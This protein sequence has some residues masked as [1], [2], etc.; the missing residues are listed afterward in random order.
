MGEVLIPPRLISIPSKESKIKNKQQKIRDTQSNHI[1]FINNV[2]ES[3]VVITSNQKLRKVIFAHCEKSKLQV[4]DSAVITTKTVE[5]FDCHNCVFTFDEVDVRI[6]HIYECN[7][8]T[9]QFSDS[10]TLIENFQIYWHGPESKGNSLQRTIIKP[11]A[12]PN[13][14]TAIPVELIEAY[15]VPDVENDDDVLLTFLEEGK[16]LRSTLNPPNDPQAKRTLVDLH[17]EIK[18]RL[19]DNEEFNKVVTN[20]MLTQ[21][22]D[23]EREEIEEDDEIVKQKAAEVAD[24]IKKGKHVVFYTG[25]G[26]ST[27]ANL[28]D[29][30]GPQGVWTLRATGNA[31]TKPTLELGEAQPTFTHYAIAELI[32]RNLVHFLT[33]TNLDGL[34]RRSGVPGSKISELHGNCYKEVCSV[35]QKEYLRSFNTLNTRTDR[36]THFTYRNCTCGGMLMDTIVHFTENIAKREWDPAVQHA[37]KSDVAVVLGTSMNVQPAASLPDKCLNNGGKLYIV[38]LQRTPYDS[39]ATTKV[40]ANTDKFMSFLIDQ[41]GITEVDMSYD[42]IIEMKEQEEREEEERLRRTRLV[43]AGAVAA[44]L[45]AL[46]G[47]ALVV[48]NRLRR[49]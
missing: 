13:K 19:E 23:K 36:W 25:A 24:A 12:D 5:I 32:R 37:R 17:A 27:S 38:N 28:P 22:Y 33:S 11:G 6:V 45:I 8:L 42:L 7:N 31:R 20:S 14:C 41:L 34:H 47:I 48:R 2:E 1:I 39:T 46:A 35:C 40:Y 29:Y 43:T 9:I 18:R 30:R 10:E 21:L 44:S 16:V 4:L 26:V 15:G 3:E 49:G